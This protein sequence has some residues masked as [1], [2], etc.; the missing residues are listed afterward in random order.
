MIEKERKFLLSGCWKAMEP[1]LRKVA[2]KREVLI[3]NYLKIQEGLF[4]GSDRP[5]GSHR[6]RETFLTSRLVRRSTLKHTN[7][8][9]LITGCRA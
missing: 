1:L 7:P 9:S 3:Q 8:R 5:L 2:E 4:P 6:V